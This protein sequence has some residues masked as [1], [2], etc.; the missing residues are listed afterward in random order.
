MSHA[1]WHCFL[2]SG[3]VSVWRRLVRRAQGQPD[4]QDANAHDPL[5]S[6][7]VY[8][9]ALPLTAQDRLLNDPAVT[10]FVIVRNPF[11]RVL[12]GWLDKAFL[13]VP[14]G[15]TPRPYFLN[16]G[17]RALPTN[18][19][20]FLRLL[21]LTPQASLDPHFMPMSS[22][23]GLATAGMKVDHVFK[24]ENISTWGPAL[25]RKLGLEKFIDDAWETSHRG[26]FFP[27]ENG[28]EERTGHNHHASE[29]IRSYYRAAD[30]AIVRE[31]FEADFELFGYSDALADARS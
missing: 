31:V 15:G 17:H 13:K 9:K 29:Q 22:F 25:V 3:G 24:L 7:L 5:K 19:S 26:G 27:A 1:G 18:F 20:E 23:C 11:T 12:S 21:K 10:S 28:N 8:L 2:P 30:A 16:G 6:G 14:D 4:W